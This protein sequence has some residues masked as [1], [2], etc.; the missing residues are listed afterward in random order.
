MPPKTRSEVAPQVEEPAEVP[1]TVTGNISAEAM[2]QALV[3]KCHKQ[4]AHETFIHN[5]SRWHA[6]A[7]TLHPHRSDRVSD[8]LLHLSPWPQGSSLEL[9]RLDAQ[10]RL[11]RQELQR[12]H[13]AA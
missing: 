3:A 6:I 13:R 1:V 12:A 8:A 2:L 5:A 10:L 11:H 7:H 9:L 4:P